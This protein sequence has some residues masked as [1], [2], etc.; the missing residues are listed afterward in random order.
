MNTL[1]LVACLFLSLGTAGAAEQAV[2]LAAG[3]AHFC[4]WTTEGRAKCWGTN[5][6]GQ[7]GQGSVESKGDTPSGMGVALPFLDFGNDALRVRSISLGTAFSCAILEHAQT[8]VA[9]VRCWGA[10]DFGQ[11]GIGHTNAVGIAPGAI[12]D[13]VP[14]ALSSIDLLAVGN[15]HACVSGNSGQKVF[16]WGNASAGQLGVS[17]TTGTFIGGKPGEIAALKPVALA[18]NGAVISLAASG[19]STC[20]VTSEHELKCWGAN[21]SG[22]LGLGDTQDRGKTPG[23]MGAGLPLVQ[24]GTNFLPRK[25]VGRGTQSRVY[26]GFC[27]ISTLHELKCFGSNFSGALGV[28]DAIAHGSTAGTMGDQLLVLNLGLS[29]PIE[30]LSC[31]LGHCC[32]RSWFSSATKCWGANQ[33]GQLGTEEMISRGLKP[34]EMG[35]SLPFLN[36]APGL[37]IVDVVTAQVSSCALF[38]NGGVKCW[39]RNT[40]GQLGQGAVFSSI[41]SRVGEMGSALA[42]TDLGL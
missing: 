37:H 7:L 34:E 28:G 33:W 41:G 11:L 1:K 16:C 23:S 35:E 17:P 31:G 30:N 12:V 27:A 6:K 36:A 14:L 3:G 9:Q 13:S 40:Q 29:M 42:W 25:V 5:A 22:Q 38:A 21:N 10:N 15:E 19:D 18:L 39:G 4:A 24:L 26:G 2:G 20:V 32:A 8:K